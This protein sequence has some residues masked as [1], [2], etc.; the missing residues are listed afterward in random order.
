MPPIRFAFSRSITAV[1][2][3]LEVFDIESGR[4]AYGAAGHR[5][6][7]LHPLV[8]ATSGSRSGREA[9]VKADEI[10]AGVCGGE[11]MARSLLWATAF[12]LLWNGAQQSK[13]DAI[14]CGTAL[15][16]LSAIF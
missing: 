2:M 8:L 14:N 11:V 16:N 6:I 4:R 1:R 7:Q 3:A 15:D 9:D 10:G 5:P 12:G 13:I